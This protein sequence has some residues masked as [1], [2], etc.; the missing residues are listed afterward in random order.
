MLY[1]NLK[2]GLSIYDSFYKARAEL[3]TKG[4]TYLIDTNIV[5]AEGNRWYLKKDVKFNTP[6]HCDPYIM[7]DVWE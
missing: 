5:D 4:K 3:A 7:I 2:D 6:T 1:K